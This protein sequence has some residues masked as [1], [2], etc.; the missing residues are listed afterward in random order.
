MAPSFIW[1]DILGMFPGF[2]EPQLPY[3]ENM[4]NARAVGMIK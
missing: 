3:K 2:L 4:T 1:G